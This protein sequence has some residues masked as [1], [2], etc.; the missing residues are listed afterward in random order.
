MADEQTIKTNDTGDKSNTDSKENKESTTGVSIVDEARAI[1]DEIVK[2]KEDLRIENDRKTKLQSEELLSSSAGGRVEVP[3]ISEEQ[4]KVD[5]AADY[6]K[7]T[8]LEKDIRK[9]N[10]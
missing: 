3:E 2:A 10:E 6:F 9:A 8:Q 4:K 1:R 7:G 5:S